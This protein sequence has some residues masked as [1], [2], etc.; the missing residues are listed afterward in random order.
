MKNSIQDLVEKVGRILD[1]TFTEDYKNPNLEICESD[2]KDGYTVYL[3]TS[4]SGRPILEEDVFYY[5]PSFDDII[6][7]L[8]DLS[9]YSEVYVNSIDS[10]FR[11]MEEELTDFCNENALEIEDYA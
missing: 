2:T 8:K 5:E 6:K 9:P 10:I 4:D 3:I 7:R 1:I 11:N